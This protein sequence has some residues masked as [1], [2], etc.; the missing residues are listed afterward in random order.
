MDG[1]LGRDEWRGCPPKS[2][3]PLG[4]QGKSAEREWGGSSAKMRR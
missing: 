2:E 4:L 3:G 1:S